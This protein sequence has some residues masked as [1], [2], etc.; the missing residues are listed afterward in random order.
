MLRYSTEVF[1][2]AARSKKNVRANY[3][4]KRFIRSGSDETH[5]VTAASADMRERS[6]ASACCHA[7]ERFA[8]GPPILET[9]TLVDT[10]A[11]HSLRLDPE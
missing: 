10:L 1:Q 11:A 4:L 5:C 9:I 8:T 3:V 2:R 6:A 7:K